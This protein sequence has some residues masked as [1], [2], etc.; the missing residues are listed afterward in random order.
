[1]TEAVSLFAAQHPQFWVRV[2]EPESLCR[3]SAAPAPS[4]LT[5][6]HFH[7]TSSLLKLSCARSAYAVRV[8]NVYHFPFD[9]L[10]GDFCVSTEI[11]SLAESGAGPA[12]PLI[13]SVAVT[14]LP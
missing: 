14:F 10:L 5:S 2:T 9:S 13:I 7:S 12:V 3:N 4:S 6:S 11:S 1:M 8:A